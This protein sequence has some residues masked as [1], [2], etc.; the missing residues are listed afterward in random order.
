MCLVVLLALHCALLEVA[1]LPGSHRMF[2]RAGCRNPV[3][4]CWVDKTQFTEDFS[5]SVTLNLVWP[6]SR[7]RCPGVWQLRMLQ[8][9]GATGES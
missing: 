9:L 3:F 4:T 8:L 5:P 7:D 2:L 1:F 6:A